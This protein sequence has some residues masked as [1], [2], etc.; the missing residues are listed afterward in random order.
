[1]IVDPALSIISAT[2]IPLAVNSVM[3]GLGIDKKAAE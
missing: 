2:P 1:M 3:T